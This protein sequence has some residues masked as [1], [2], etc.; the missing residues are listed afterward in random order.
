MRVIG[1]GLGRTG[2]YSLKIALETLLNGRCY[3]MAEI[4]ERPADISVWHRA[5]VGERVDWPSLFEGYVAGVDWP[6]CSFAVELARVFPDALI[7]LSIRDFESWWRSASTTIFPSSRQAEGEWRQMVEAVFG[8]RFTGRLDDK[9][10]CREAFERHYAHVRNNIPASRILEWRTGEGWEPVCEALDLPVPD[11]EF[12]HLNT[13]EQF[14]A[15]R[16][17]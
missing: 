12:P 3:H 14:L 10:A 4:F 7:L 5:A 1:A 2:T 11:E 15:R 8:N 17:G 13:A 16:E 6:V 9:E